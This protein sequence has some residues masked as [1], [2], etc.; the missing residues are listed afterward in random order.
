VT[1]KFRINKI[2]ALISGI[3]VLGYVAL[4]WCGKG[5]KC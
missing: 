5:V 3:M 1:R 4:V 2:T